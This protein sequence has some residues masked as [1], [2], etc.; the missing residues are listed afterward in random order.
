MHFGKFRKQSDAWTRK[1][2][3]SADL[4]QLELDIMK[5]TNGE[6]NNNLPRWM[7]ESMTVEQFAKYFDIVE[8]LLDTDRRSIAGLFLI[9]TCPY[10]IRFTALRQVMMEANND[11]RGI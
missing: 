5:L 9:H 3:T 10:E 11:E 2:M 4:R 6:S 8:R 1:A 7:D